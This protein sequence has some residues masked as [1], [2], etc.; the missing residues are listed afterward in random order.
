MHFE[1][2]QILWLSRLIVA[3]LGFFF[4]WS[5]QKR[6]KLLNQFVHA[7][8]VK[9]LTLGLSTNRRLTK[10]CLI[11]SAV[12]LL[13]VSVAR[14]KL[15]FEWQEMETQGLDILVAVDTSKSMLASDQSPNRIER[16]KLAVQDLMHLAKS[17]RLGLIAF[18]G[19]AFLPVSYTHLTLPT[20]LLV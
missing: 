12:T 19:T 6:S 9:Q 4:W 18:S 15:G 5:W 7:N 3:L 16:A 20:I 11:M 2:S 8:L 17:D 1:Y 13:L 10:I 14:P